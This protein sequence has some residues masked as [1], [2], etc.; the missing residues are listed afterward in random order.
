MNYWLNVFTG[1]TWREFQAAGQK[2]TGFREH[3]GNR[4]K[5]ITPGDLF[6]CYMVG[7]KRWADVTGLVIGFNEAPE[8]ILDRSHRP[9]AIAPRR[10]SAAG[11]P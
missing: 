3:N 8:S 2:M 1:K 6:L 7:V 10:G 9:R 4:A 11:E 5:S